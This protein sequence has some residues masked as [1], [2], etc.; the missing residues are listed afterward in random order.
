MQQPI[1]AIAGAR[2]GMTPERVVGWG[3]VGLLH[4]VAFW[5]I[6][7]SLV[8]QIRPKKIDDIVIVD[9]TSDK[10]KPLPFKHPPKIPDV[11]LSRDHVVQVPPPD[12]TIARDDP[13]GIIADPPRPTQP[14]GVP[15]TAVSGILSTHTTPPYPPVDRRFGNQG[16][17]KLR[18]TISPQGIV[19]AA[20]VIQSSGF[21]GLD[22]AAM[23]WVMQHWKYKPAIQGGVPVAS[24]AVAAVVF[25]IRNAG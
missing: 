3:F 25:D 16:T 6:V 22:Q 23:S 2:R 24:T 14:P 7:T 21:A 19:T 17:V 18:L 15:D 9:T 13:E 1:H 10:H 12:F 4:L 8:P 11:D 20:D 5:A